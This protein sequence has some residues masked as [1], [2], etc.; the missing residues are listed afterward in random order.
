LIREKEMKTISIEPRCPFCKDT[1]EQ[2]KELRERKPREF[3]LGVCE[4]CGAVYAYDATGHNRGAA[5]VEALL[6][7]CNC[8]DYVAFSLSAGEDYEDAVIE[9]YDPFSNKII[10]GGTFEDRRVRGTLI[11]VK[12]KPE[13]QAFTK[14]M[15]KDK[16]RSSFVSVPAKKSR[17]DQFSREKVQTYVSENR[18]EELVALAEEDTR[19]IPELLRMFYTPDEHLRW[20]IIEIFSDVCA[21]IGEKRPDVVSKFLNRLLLS[22][23]DSA[24]S[25]WGAL[26]AVGATISKSP[27]LFGKFS[28]ALLSFL[29]YKNYWK[30]VTWAIGMIATAR[31]DLVKLAYR[32]I[33]SFLLVPDPAIRGHAAW[34]LGKLGYKDAKEDLEKLL[35]D[36]QQLSLYREG[37]LQKVTV[38]Q[39]AKEAVEKLS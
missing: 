6:F 14:D 20:R 12:L 4:K 21:R 34:A 26:E 15:T 36:N 24:S 9:N 32:A 13:L 2:S 31:P 19:V 5:F 39:L 1:I 11:F 29:Q 17:S 37:E 10:P 23:A 18:L 38:S 8:D 16:I 35:S 25:A 33:C 30:E 3:P 27:D 7:A 28:H 22:A